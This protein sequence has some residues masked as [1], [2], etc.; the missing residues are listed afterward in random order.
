MRARPGRI[1]YAKIDVPEL[2]EVAVFC[3][4][5]TAVSR[6][7]LRSSYE[8]WEGENIAHVAAAIDW[9]DEKTDD[10][11]QVILLGD[12][13]TSPAVPA[14]DILPGG[15]SYAQLPKRASTIRSSTAT[16]HLAPLHEQRAGARKDTGVGAT[17]DHVMIRGISSR[18]T[19]ERILDEPVAVSGDEDAGVP[20][21]LP[22][23]DHYGVEATFYE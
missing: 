14:D 5:F 2:G 13:N 6:A 21:E 19:A 23:S 9:I 10:D 7:Q 11:T 12:L 22:L 8:T 1:L 16:M 15:Q 18:V 20:N 17:L 4:H 3:T